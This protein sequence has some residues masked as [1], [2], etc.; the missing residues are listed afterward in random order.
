MTNTEEIDTNTVTVTDTDMDKIIIHENENINR[1]YHLPHCNNV[2]EV[3]Q[4]D[5][6]HINNITKINYNIKTNTNHTDNKYHSRR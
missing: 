2:T 6:Y 1:I 4:M 3:N 5:I